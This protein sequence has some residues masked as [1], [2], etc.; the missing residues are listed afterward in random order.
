MIKSNLLK[1]LLSIFIIFNLFWINNSFASNT[2]NLFATWINN[3]YPISFTKDWKT[4]NLSWI[5]N[6]LN[7]N[8]VL[9]VKIEL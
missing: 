8:N 7:F 2:S 9:F 3:S 1:I 6:S 4:I 5:Y